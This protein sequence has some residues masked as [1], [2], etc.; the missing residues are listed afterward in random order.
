YFGIVKAMYVL[1]G[2]EEERIS[3]PGPVFASIMIAL[4]GIV[5]AAI[6]VGPIF[7]FG[8]AAGSTLFP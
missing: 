7:E 8:V 1:E 4:A 5:I 6:L 2:E 3:V